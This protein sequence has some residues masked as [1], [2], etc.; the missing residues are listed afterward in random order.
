MSNVSRVYR[1]VIEDRTIRIDQ[2]K[3]LLSHN[4]NPLFYQ[5]IKYLYE[6]HNETPESPQSADDVFVFD[7]MTF[8]SPKV[9]EKEAS[10]SHFREDEFYRWINPLDQALMKI[11]EENIEQ[12]QIVETDE[13]ISVISAEDITVPAKGSCELRINEIELTLPAGYE[14]TIYRNVRLSSA[15]IEIADPVL[16]FGKNRIRTLRLINRSG[17]DF[18]IRK[19]STVGSVKKGII[20]FEKLGAIKQKKKKRNRNT[21]QHYV[22]RKPGFIKTVFSDGINYQKPTRRR[23]LLLAY[24]L[25]MNAEQ[26]REL[27]QSIDPDLPI[28]IWNWYEVALF[29]A[30]CR[31]DITLNDLDRIGLYLSAQKDVTIPEISLKE[32]KNTKVAWSD[33]GDLIHKEKEESLQEIGKLLH[34]IKKADKICSL[35]AKRE[36]DEMFGYVM[37]HAELI[38][39][40]D[41]AKKCKP[42]KD[43]NEKEIR[44]CRNAITEM[45]F[46]Y[47]GNQVP[48]VYGF[49]DLQGMKSLPH[50]KHLKAVDEATRDTA[51]TEAEEDA[52]PEKEAVSKADLE[53]AFFL[54][55]VLE[56]PIS[57]E[58]VTD[59]NPE[60]L[61][62]KR[63]SDYRLLVNEFLTDLHFTEVRDMDP[64]D[65]KLLL[66]MQEEYPIKT[67]QN[68]MKEI[69]QIQRNRMQVELHDI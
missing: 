5:L 8:P 33:L 12:Q 37:E 48:Y 18:S 65:G 23:L 2:K 21:L 15:K 39:K 56:H 36:L 4:R 64:F 28:N 49:S 6:N 1:N 52:A 42:K 46:P 54:K 59:V 7:H 58:E 61:I 53:F 16:P 25:R 32:M 63:A 24:A 40:G 11:A 51:V 68:T 17:K 30:I 55:F 60:E 22:S 44:Q 47:Y 27:M 57:S 19:G 69:F 31:G 3:E 66:C 62:R 26:T 34:I 29:Y 13:A 38:F 45:F 14:A 50:R 41:Y 10:L 67:L 35:Q 43:A 9:S 20:R